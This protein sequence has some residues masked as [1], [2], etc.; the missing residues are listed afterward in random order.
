MSR[1]SICEELLEASQYLLVKFRRSQSAVCKLSRATVWS[2]SS[3]SYL[4]RMGSVTSISILHGD[5][6][7]GIM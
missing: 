2:L 3:L 5:V 6:A 4:Q 7:R 1:T